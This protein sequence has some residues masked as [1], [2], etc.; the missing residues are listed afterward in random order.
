MVTTTAPPDAGLRAASLVHDLLAAPGCWQD[1][2]RYPVHG[3][4]YTRLDVPD[5][6]A[7]DAWV[8]TWAPGSGLPRHDH[9]GAAGAIAVVEGELVELHGATAVGR[10]RLL[11][12]GSVVSFGVDHVHE[13]QNVGRV[14]A[15]SLHVY[16][17]GLG[18]MRF[19]GD[20]PKADVVVDRL[21]ARR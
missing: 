20:S 18:T 7:A 21:G 16:A 3:R 19:F 5:G 17:P 14:P 6:S 9:G 11:R 12:P 8:I 4:A 13:V 2:V 15:V 10:R 1:C